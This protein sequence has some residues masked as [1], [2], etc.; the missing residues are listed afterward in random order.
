MVR[1]ARRL[2]TVAAA[3]ILV[4]VG[5]AAALRGTQG[6][7]PTLYVEYTMNCTFSIVDDSGKKVTAI[8]PGTYQVFVSTPVMFKLVEPSDHPAASDFT[9]CKGWVQFQL[10]GPGVNLSTT[11]DA[12]C[13]AY[14]MLPSMAFVPGATYTAQ[15]LNLPSA[16]RTTFTTLTSGTPVVPN[17]PY[18]T[19]WGK[20]SST[21]LIGSKIATV[22]RGTLSGSLSAGGAAALQFKGKPVTTLKQGRYLVSVTDSDP[23]STF[24]LQSGKGKQKVLT[25]GAWVGHRSVTITLTP[26]HWTYFS[27][28]GVARTFDVA[29]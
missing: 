17:S 9:G 10:T 27:G 18:A 25:G 13:D 19:I 29:S 3:A 6:A 15:D 26:G 24:A 20:V 4:P 16:T 14:L 5:S 22:L 21:D 28:R 8:A 2:A 1:S 23:H 12:G 11:L 7:L